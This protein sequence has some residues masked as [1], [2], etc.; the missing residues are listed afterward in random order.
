MRVVFMG[1]PEFAVPSL[2]ALSARHDVIAVYTRPDA[3]SGRGRRVRPSAVKAA[4]EELGLEVAQPA[5]LRDA[6][7]L[8]DL[9]LLGADIIVV[10]AYGVILPLQVLEAARLGAINVHAS[11]LPRWRGA[12]PIQRAILAGDDV[13][14]V[15]IMLMQAGLDTGPYCLQDHLPIGESTARDLTARLAEV[16]ASALLRAL[17][18][19]EAGTAQWVTQDEEL[20]TYA[21]KIT[22]DDVAVGPDMLAS[23]VATRVRASMPAAP[24]RVLIGGRGVTLLDA[25]RADEPLGAGE[26]GRT[27]SALLLGAHEGAVAVTR[28]KP[29]GKAEMDA[30]AWARGL[31][32][33]ETMTWEKLR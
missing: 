3:V 10:A 31:H 27:T 24:S 1:T 23:D 11:L 20:V 15:S 18:S 30:C 8:A 21:G 28:V 5:S 7:A 33:F 13:A 12:A 4:A 22:K 16:G 17:P 25:R 14:G 6:E 26:I 29:D 19:I 9:K 32:D 2:R